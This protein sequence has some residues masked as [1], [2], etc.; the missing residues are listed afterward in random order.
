VRLPITLSYIHIQFHCR[1][2]D[3]SAL[4]KWGC[5]VTRNFKLKKGEKTVILIF[6]AVRTSNLIHNKEVHDW[7]S[8]PNTARRLNQEK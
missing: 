1:T 6:T 8:S 5:E 7:Y 3:T 2:S 4:W